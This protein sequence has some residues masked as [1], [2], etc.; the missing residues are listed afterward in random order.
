MLI[1][2]LYYYD[3]MLD[4]VQFPLTPENADQVEVFGVPKINPTEAEGLSAIEIG[5]IFRDRFSTAFEEVL[6]EQKLGFTSKFWSL[7]TS[8]YSQK[9]LKLATTSKFQESVS[10]WASNGFKV[11]DLPEI[12][13]L[14]RFSSS[15]EDFA[16]Y[17]GLKVLYLLTSANQTNIKSEKVEH[18]A[19][20]EV[21]EVSN[22]QEILV[23]TTRFIA[24]LFTNLNCAYLPLTQDPKIALDKIREEIY[25]N[26]HI[27]LIIVEGSENTELVKHL[28]RNLPPTILITN[29]ELENN[30]SDTSQTY[31]DLLV[32]KTLGIRIPN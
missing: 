25:Q 12:L 14:G 32:K 10:E 20:E 16:L 18:Q 26:S 13:K 8:P 11:S 6:R 28:Q 4:Q 17:Y 9:D 24:P 15:P 7:L 31:F 19:S 5:T 1:G 30:N 2:E 22:D 27:K 3:K 21:Q 23:L 29:L